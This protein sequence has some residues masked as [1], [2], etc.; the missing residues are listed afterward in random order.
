METYNNNSKLD[1][2]LGSV[3]VI[4]VGALLTS[5][6]VVSAILL[7]IVPW[8]LSIA[9]VPFAF[10]A[11]RLLAKYSAHFVISLAIYIPF[12]N[13]ILKWFPP[14]FQTVARF[15]PEFIIFALLGWI[16]VTHWCNRRR[17]AWPANILNI[18]LVFFLGIALISAL[19]NNVPL[20]IMALA[21]KNLLRY[22]G[23]YY[24]ILFIRL[25]KDWIQF[26]LK[27]M[28]I[29]ACIQAILAVVEAIGGVAVAALLRP[30]V[31][32]YELLSG[33]SNPNI[34][35]GN[36][37]PSGTIGIY[38]SFGA[39]LAF[40]AFFLIAKMLVERRVLYL[41]PTFLLTIGIFLSRSRTSWLMLAIGI[42]IVS[43]FCRK[44]FFNKLVFWGTIVLILFISLSSISNL[45]LFGSSAPQ[46]TDWN[47]LIID[48]SDGQLLAK[49]ETISQRLTEIFSVDYWQNSSRLSTFLRT[50]P[51]LIRNY[52][53]LGVGPGT[54]GSEVTGGGST[55]SGIYTQYS[56]EEWLDVPE[57][58]IIWTADSG[59]VAILAQFGL[60]G[61]L[62]WW[63]FFI[64]LLQTAYRLYRSTTELTVR[65]FSVA[66][67]ANIVILFWA[68]FSVHFLTYRAV[69]LYFWITAAILV[70]TYQEATRK[71]RENQIVTAI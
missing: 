55:S 47:S 13:F 29:A 32:G 21:L 68:T 35:F 53:L 34:A 58:V 17:L 23:L 70:L 63:T 42:G 25:D 62:A 30:D 5:I 24:L 46:L 28:L 43:I 6:L 64:L 12:E 20:F 71:A 44:Q 7:N 16:V 3:A 49:P 4:G 14:N 11:L 19:V 67:I 36:A 38:S 41:V 56:H 40:W 60:L 66:M 22:I 33:I 15:A 37:K 52:P 48:N 8:L 57:S 31:T 27:T 61:L 54:L 9:A 50:V 39:F 59:W 2:R 18:P 26:F 45:N 10:L 65:W 1:R 51:E 69:S